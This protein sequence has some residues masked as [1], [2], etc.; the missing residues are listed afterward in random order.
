MQIKNF[1]IITRKYL[2]KSFCECNCL[3]LIYNIYNDLGIELKSFQKLYNGHN[4]D[5]YMSYW[6][7]DPVA[8]INDMIAVLKL[9]GKETDIRFLKRGDIVVIQYKDV[10][11]PSI[12]IGGNVVML[13]TLESGITTLSIGGRFKPIMARRII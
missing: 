6:E 13:A 7:K 2:G 12:Y 3:Q 11:F 1:G 10:K 9:T 8:S 4:M 5:N